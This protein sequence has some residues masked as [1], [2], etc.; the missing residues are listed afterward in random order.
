LIPVRGLQPVG[1]GAFFDHL[2]ARV[3]VDDVRHALLSVRHNEQEAKEKA[4]AAQADMG[5]RFGASAVGR[6][7]AL[8][9]EEAVQAQS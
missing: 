1:E 4:A 8:L 3:D 6:E 2:W 7:L 9:L 5:I